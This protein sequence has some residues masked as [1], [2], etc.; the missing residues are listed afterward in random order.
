[1]QYIRNKNGIA[2]G[3]L[4]LVSNGVKQVYSLN[5]TRLLGWYDPKSD[6]T[7][8]A[9]TGSWMGYGDQTLFLLSDA[10]KQ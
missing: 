10:K 7:I 4:N 9:S 8:S 6:K 1:M 5:P 2:I 3:M